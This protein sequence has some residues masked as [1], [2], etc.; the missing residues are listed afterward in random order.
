MELET[1]LDSVFC[2]VDQPR[3][4]IQHSLPM[5]IDETEFFYEDESFVF[6]SI[7]FYSESKNL[8][9]EKRDVK[10]KKGKSHSEINLGNMRPSQ[11]SRLHRATRD[12]LDDSIGGIEAENVRLKDRVK[13]LEESLIPMPLFVSPLA[14]TMPVHPCSQV[15]RILQ[16]PRIV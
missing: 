1:D 12:A 5:E 8:I 6:Q 10:N 7:V 4:A 16:P 14:I 15:K 3:D 13:E 11:I 9:I 2:N